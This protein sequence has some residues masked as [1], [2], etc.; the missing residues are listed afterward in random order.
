VE[1]ARKSDYPISLRTHIPV[2]TSVI[3]TTHFKCEEILSYFS[4]EQLLES[5]STWRAT[6]CPNR[7]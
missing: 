6:A 1:S 5:D 2:L 4:G 7:L 3:N